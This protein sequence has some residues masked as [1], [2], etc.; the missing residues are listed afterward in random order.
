M[1]RF[2]QIV[3]LILITVALSVFGCSE[4]LPEPQHPVDGNGVLPGEIIKMESD[5]GNAARLP[6][7][8]RDSI[9]GFAFKIWITGTYTQTND[10]MFLDGTGH[11][12][13]MG[14]VSILQSHFVTGRDSIVGGLFRYVVINGEK[15]DDVII[16]RS[17]KEDEVTGTYKGVLGLVES[18]GSR[19][20]EL[21][22]EITS[23]TGHFDGVIGIINIEGVLYPDGTFSFVSDGWMLNTHAN[24]Q[25]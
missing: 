23:G 1:K 7:T 14:N 8:G 24:K 18:D 25:N 3:R 11:A 5:R 13:H 10:E 2:N 20:F 17:A 16:E 21:R 9:K 4:N 22:E 19:T 15:E 6:F 12:T